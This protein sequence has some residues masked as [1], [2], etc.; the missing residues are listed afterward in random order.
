LGISLS[1]YIEKKRMELASELLLHGEN[2][3]TDVARK[4]GFTNDNT[5]YK[6]YKRTFGHSPTAK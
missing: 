2:S 3:V 4:C 6:A 1:A 5:F